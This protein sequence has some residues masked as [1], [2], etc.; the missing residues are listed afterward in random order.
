M[1]YTFGGGKYG[2]GKSTLAIHF[3]MWLAQKDGPVLLVDGD[4]ETS[5][6]ERWNGERNLTISTILARAEGKEEDENGNLVK[7]KDVTPIVARSL[8]KRAHILTERTKGL[9]VTS[10]SAANIKSEIP[11]LE[12]NYRHIVIDVAGKDSKAQRNAML[13]C[14]HVIAPVVPSGPDAWR[15][16]EFVEKVQE[17]RDL[18][19][20][21]L[22][23]HL[24]VNR[25]GGARMLKTATEYFESLSVEG[26][27]VLNA[28]IATRSAVV[29]AITDGLTVWELPRRL[30]SPEIMA[31]FDALCQE[32]SALRNEAMHA[33]A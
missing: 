30:C 6:T 33:A 17:A 22:P 1:I 31:E 3:A 12:S 11:K 7:V 13:V 27:G 28:R 9:T 29:E 20:V 8:E 5:T 18:R 25:V 4:E 21:D 19:A 24:V 14:D 32:I 15:L 23:V 2:A 10:L 16:P 26:I